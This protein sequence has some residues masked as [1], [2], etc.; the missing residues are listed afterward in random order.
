MRVYICSST[1]WDLSEGG[2]D[3]STTAKQR[4]CSKVVSRYVASG[5]LA[6]LLAAKDFSDR[7]PRRH[8]RIASRIEPDLALASLSVDHFA[9]VEEAFQQVM[10]TAGFHRPNRGA[11]R[12]KRS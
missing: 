8:E 2:I 9:R 3:G 10:E 1:V 5:D 7:E 11:W 12:K 4:V 6:L